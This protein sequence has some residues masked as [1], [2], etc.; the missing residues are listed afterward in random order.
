M[1]GRYHY[2]SDP[3]ILDPVDYLNVLIGFSKIGMDKIPK[4]LFN[5]L[6]EYFILNFKLFSLDDLTKILLCFLRSC[7][8][9]DFW[10]K[11]ETSIVRHIDAKDENNKVTIQYIKDVQSPFALIGIS[12]PTIWKAFATQVLMNLESIKTDVDFLMDCIFCF[13]RVQAVT[14][15][16]FWK[17]I[18]EVLST[19][20]NELEF[21][22]LTYLG[23]TIS[24]VNFQKDE[25]VKL[26]IFTENKEFWEKIARLIQKHMKTIKN[27]NIV[28]GDVSDSMT[29]I[30][31]SIMNNL[32][33]AIN[34][35]NSLFESVD[36]LEGLKK[37]VSEIL[38]KL[39]K[40][41]K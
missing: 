7:K 17:K 38:L 16:V 21:D 34:E 28:K 39:I 19:K 8:D 30:K 12:H 2:N 25:K 40:I 31:I 1:D 29:N 10:R 27:Q 13:T 32:L 22:D 6:K 4:N 18:I 3:E 20:L 26:L 36:D 11:F 33:T 37:D 41:L 23:I 9:E 15:V 35:N 24:P 5:E 14:S